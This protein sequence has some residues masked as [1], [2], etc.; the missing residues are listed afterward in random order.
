MIVPL[1]IY[2]ILEFFRKCWK[3][4][5][6]G[7]SAKYCPFLINKWMFMLVVVLITALIEIVR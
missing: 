4:Y 7:E 5:F 2:L 3:F 1:F 6:A